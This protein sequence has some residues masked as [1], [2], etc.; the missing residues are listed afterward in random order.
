EF[1]RTQKGN[2]NAY[3]QDNEIS[4]FDWTL[5]DGDQ[6]AELLQ[7]T[8]RLAAIRRNFPDPRV[9]LHG[10]E[11][12]SPGIAD[13]EWFDERGTRLCEADWSNAEGRALILYLSQTLANR[14]ARVGAI[15]MNASGDALEFHLLKNVRWRMLLDSAAPTRGETALDQPLYRIEPHAAVMFHGEAIE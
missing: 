6:G 7:F 3:C 10:T 12:I 8:Q 13:M 5:K 2:N 4:W 15:A 9:F 11:Q 14:A 1:C